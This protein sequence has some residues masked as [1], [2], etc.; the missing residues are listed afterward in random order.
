MSDVK[1]LKIMEHSMMPTDYAT[2]LTSDEMRD[3]VAYLAHQSL[4]PRGAFQ[5]SA[6][7]EK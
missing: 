6:Q 2:R 1:D 4:R 7:N 3:L 5:E